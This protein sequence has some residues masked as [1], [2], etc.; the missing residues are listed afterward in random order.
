MSTPKA[1]N[2]VF[3]DGFYTRL[4]KPRTSGMNVVIDKCLGM[5]ALAD[6]L[7]T[8][9][10][11]ID[12]VKCAF[13]TSFALDEKMLREKIAMLRSYNIDVYPG[14]TLCEAAIVQCVA[15]QFLKRARA[16]GFTMVEVSDGTIHLTSEDRA[17][18]IRRALDVG[19]Q[20]ITEVGKKDPRHQLGAGRMAQQIAA[21]L[22]MGASYV[23]VEARES[24]KGV[25]IF[26]STGAVDVNE[27][28]VLVSGIRDLGRIIWEAPQTAQQSYLIQR[29]GPKVNLAN[30][31][32]LEVLALEAL[33]SGMRFETL[34]PI[35]AERGM[36]ERDENVLSRFLEAAQ[37]SMGA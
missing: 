23:I 5:R 1:W 16:L 24:G 9:S 6:L 15:P 8:A 19:L 13:G 29:F 12:Q 20:V 7:E 2:G 17:A 10:D 14:G 30:I 4:S 36:L 26:D 11:A 31:P 21:D 22:E 34:R 32:P 25:G 35:A 37:N 18:V 3:R 27:L 28:D 33:R